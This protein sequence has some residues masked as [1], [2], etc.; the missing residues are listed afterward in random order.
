MNNRSLLATFAVAGSLFL[1]SSSARP[2]AEK[3]L[4]GKIILLDPGH[5]VKNEAGSIIN[6]GARARKGPYERDLALDVAAMIVPLLESQ[7]AK[8][9]MTRTPNN[10]WRYSARK[11]A[12][13]RGRAIEANI[14]R[15]DAYIRIH[16]DWNRSKQFKGFTTYYYRWGS[17][18]LAKSI[19]TALAKAQPNKRDNGVKRKSFVSA[20]ARMPSVLLE[21]GVLSNPGDVK[22]LKRTDYQLLLAQAVAE[23]IITYFK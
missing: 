3:P 16:L 21:L 17:R 23:G 15:A 13:N 10:P 4:A 1:L 12:D 5:A 19:N 9:Y 8:V 2:S 14:L 22:D 18:P 6:P 20:S 7:G 11:Q